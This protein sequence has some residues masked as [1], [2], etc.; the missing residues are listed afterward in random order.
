MVGNEREEYSL[1][2]APSDPEDGTPRVHLPVPTRRQLSE[3]TSLK[4]TVCYCCIMVLNGGLV[5]ADGA[6]GVL[7]VGGGGDLRHRSC[8]WGWEATPP[9]R[10]RATTTGALAGS[11][12]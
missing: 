2:E 5:G 6:T 8:G 4:L 12:R 9:R 7:D 11:S 3:R 10:L 1:L